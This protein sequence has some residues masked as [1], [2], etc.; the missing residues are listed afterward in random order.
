ML[1]LYRQH[2]TGETADTVGH[3][4]ILYEMARLQRTTDEWVAK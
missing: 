3:S 4:N 2:Y 1:E